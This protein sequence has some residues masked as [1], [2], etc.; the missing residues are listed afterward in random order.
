MLITQVLS[1]KALQ[2]AVTTVLDM[3][4]EFAGYVE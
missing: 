1:K 4:G 2:A 3:D